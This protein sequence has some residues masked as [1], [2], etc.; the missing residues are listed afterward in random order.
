MHLTLTAQENDKLQA[1]TLR[2]KGNIQRLRL[3]RAYVPYVPNIL[4]HSIL[5]ERLEADMRNAPPAKTSAIDPV[6]DAKAS[7]ESAESK[8]QDVSAEP[9]SKMED[10]AITSELEQ[11]L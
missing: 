6:R 7:A 11:T 9:S 3:E 8:E 1:T 4:Q 5:Y 2:I 10:D